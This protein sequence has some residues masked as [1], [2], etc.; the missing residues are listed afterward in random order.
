MYN[1]IITLIE[2]SV[3]NLKYKFSYTYIIFATHKITLY[4]RKTN[5]NRKTKKVIITA[6]LILS[7][8]LSSLEDITVNAQELPAISKENVIMQLDQRIQL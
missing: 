6:A 2:R 1:I 7:M 5:E 8:G 4:W 3:W